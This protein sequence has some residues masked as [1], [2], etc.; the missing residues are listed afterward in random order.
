MNRLGKGNFLRLGWARI[1]AIHTTTL[2]PVIWSC[3]HAA[4][5]LL[6]RRHKGIPHIEKHSNKSLTGQSSKYLLG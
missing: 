1:L 6:I 4:S 3:N 2:G 5:K